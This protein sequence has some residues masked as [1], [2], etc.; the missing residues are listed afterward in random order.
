MESRPVRGLLRGVRR[1][2]EFCELGSEAVW[3]RNRGGAVWGWS[4]VRSGRRLG[5]WDQAGGVWRDLVQCEG[6]WGGVIGVEKNFWD[7]LEGSGRVWRILDPSTLLQQVPGRGPGG[8]RGGR[9]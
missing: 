6:V 8:Q 1:S 7:L 4:F 3:D 5:V 2:A 9:V